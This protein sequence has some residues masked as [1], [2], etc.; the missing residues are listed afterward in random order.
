MQNY[1]YIILYYHLNILNIIY[2]IVTSKNANS[3]EK[4]NIDQ[5]NVR[6]KKYI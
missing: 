3:N 2:L 5:Q 6:W 1:R 4:H